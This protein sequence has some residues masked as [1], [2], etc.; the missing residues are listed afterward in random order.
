M[1]SLKNKQPFLIAIGVAV[2]ATCLLAWYFIIPKAAAI[3]LPYRW[4]QIPLGQKRVI[5][6]RFLGKATH[7][8][9]TALLIKGE[10]WIAHRTNG[11][12]CLTIYYNQDTIADAYRLTFDYQLGFLHKRYLLKA[13]SRH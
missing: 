1:S 4:E 3:N 10:E 13:E 11:N 5:A 2:A 12:Y 9:S 8:D 7:S 6:E